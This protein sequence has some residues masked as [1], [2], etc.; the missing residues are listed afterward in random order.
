V[1]DSDAYKNAGNA[2]P[3]IDQLALAD[4]GRNQGQSQ[5]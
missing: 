4:S 3:L 1:H 2:K 5:K